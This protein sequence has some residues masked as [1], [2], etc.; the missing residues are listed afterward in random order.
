LTQGSR[1]GQAALLYGA[2][3]LGGLMMEENVVATTGTRFRITRDD[4][5]GLIRQAGDEPRQ[6]DGFYR[7]V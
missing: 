3:D 7:L 5:A 1:V 4:M 6:R 2:N